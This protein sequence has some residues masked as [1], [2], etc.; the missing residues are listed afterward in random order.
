MIAAV[1]NSRLAGATYNAEKMSTLSKDMADDI[2][3]RLKG[4]FTLSHNSRMS[5]PAPAC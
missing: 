4:V 5:A 2:K 3:H 1:L